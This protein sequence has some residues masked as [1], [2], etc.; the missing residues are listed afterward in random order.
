MS[1][2]RIIIPA[3]AG[4]G[5]TILAVPMVRRLKQAWPD[6]RITILARN[7]SM[8]EPLR[9]LAEV[10]EVLYTGV[11]IRALFRAVTWTW[12]R[13]PDVYLV[14]FP[15]SRWHY[16]LLAMISFAPQKI[17]HSYPIYF[18]TFGFIGRRL[19]ATPGI[20]DIEQNLRL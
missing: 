7:E 17:L 1:S 5:N 20:H 6:A 12:Q 10:D 2:R 9:R 15:S 4:V 16:G 14:P 13:R 11:G 18:R 3:L 19:A 8:G